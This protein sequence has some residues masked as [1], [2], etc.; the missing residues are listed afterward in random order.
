[1]NTEIEKVGGGLTGEL[2]EELGEDHG[3]DTIGAATVL[4][5]QCHHPVLWRRQSNTVPMAKRPSTAP[6]LER[7]PG[8]QTPS[9][10][11]GSGDTTA[12]AKEEGRNPS[13]V[14]P[15]QIKPRGLDQLGDARRRWRRTL[16]KP[17]NRH[18]QMEELDEAER[19]PH[20]ATMKL[21]GIEQQSHR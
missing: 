18:G 5:S 14:K 12:C 1:M 8:L 6:H 20:M 21:A 7:M 15:E 19:M 10:W 17:M 3:G 11:R 4:A 13:E 9:N 2:A 16:A